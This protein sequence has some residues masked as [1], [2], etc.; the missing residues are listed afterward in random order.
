[1]L[2]MRCSN[3]DNT[4]IKNHVLHNTPVSSTDP[5]NL[6]YYFSG[7]TD[8]EG[9]FCISINKSNRHK[10]GW[11]IRPS[12]SISQN[13]NR[14]QVLEMLKT[15]FDCGSLR[16]DRSDNTIKYEIR[17]LSDLINRVIPHFEKYPILSLKRKDFD[18]FAKVCY[19]MLLGE[20]LTRS[21]FNSIIDLSYQMN[22]SGKRKYKRSE[23]KI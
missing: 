7:Y 13:R 16:P 19:L 15:Y 10:F 18:L 23:I 1:M 5:R 20:H 14:S 21:G 9:C 8:G 11:E 6:P 17:S 3:F 12:F 22:E 2:D 4:N